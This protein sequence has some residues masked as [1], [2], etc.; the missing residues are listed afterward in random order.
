MIK[1]SYWPIYKFGP[2]KAMGR[3]WYGIEDCII[4]KL[5]FYVNH[6]LIQLQ[7]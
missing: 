1:V 5:S 3:T 2:A 7:Y 6:D 4:F